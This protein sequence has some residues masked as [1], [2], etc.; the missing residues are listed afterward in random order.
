MIGFQ[1][2]GNRLKIMNNTEEYI[3]YEK[4]KETYKLAIDRGLT[5]GRLR[6]LTLAACLYIAC[7]IHGSPILL[8]D[9]A[10]VLQVRFP[11]SN[12]RTACAFWTV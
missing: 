10:Q 2:L 3:L 9:F 4:A 1:E 5:H 11:V 12:S 7:R 6:Q 8:I